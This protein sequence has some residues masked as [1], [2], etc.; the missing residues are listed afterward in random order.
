MTP[1]QIAAS[2]SPAAKRT[3]LNMRPEWC[4][5]WNAQ[6]HQYLTSRGLVDHIAGNCGTLTTLGLAVRNILENQK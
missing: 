2:L 6:G 1:A 5:S 4:C 3:I